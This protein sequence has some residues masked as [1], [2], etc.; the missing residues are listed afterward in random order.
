MQN[1]TMNNKYPQINLVFD[2]RKTATPTVKSSVDVRICYDYKQKFIST[3]VKLNSTQWKNGKIINCPDIIQVSQILNKMLTDIRQI[4]YDMMNEGHIDLSAISYRLKALY[5]DKIS[6]IDF[7]KQRTEIRKYGKKKDTQERYDR[8]LKKFQEYGKIIEFKDINDTAIIKYDKYLI[9]QGML[10]YSKWNNYHRFLNSFCIDAKE[11]GYITRNPYKWVNIEKDKSDGGLDKYLT[12][13]E[14]RIIKKAK[15]PTESL[16]R[17]RDL[18][19]FQTYTCLRYSDLYLFNVKYIQE[20]KGMKVYIHKAKKTRKYFTVPILDPAWDILMKYNRKLPIIS[21]V[22]YNLYLKSVAQA[23]GIDKPLSTHW[24]RHTGATLLINERVDSNIIKKIC[25]H[26]SIRIT[27]QV[28]AKLLDE[29]V[30][31]AVQEIKENLE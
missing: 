10:P 27:E 1:L 3:G 14:F 5:A 17:V 18:F 4:I 26:S 9:G 21:N 7:C 20:M 15:M 23:A 22:K 24:A 8:F 28:Y 29:T 31:D 19:V 30:V 6:F 13:E 16:E 12:P 25:G 11:E 2:R